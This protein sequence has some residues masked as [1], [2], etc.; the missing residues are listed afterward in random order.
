MFKKTRELLQEREAQ[1]AGAAP[2]TFAE[3]PSKNSQDLIYSASDLKNRVLLVEQGTIQDVIPFLRLYRV[4]LLKGHIISCTYS[5]DS[6]FQPLGVTDSTVLSPGT[7]V[8]IARLPNEP[9]GVIISVI[10]DFVKTYGDSYA[11]EIVQAS[12]AGFVSDLV[13]KSIMYYQPPGGGGIYS[14]KD[15]HLDAIP[16]DWAR[17]S[18]LGA[19]LFLSDFLSGFRLNEYCGIWLH[20]MDSLLR[21]AGLNYQL[22]TGGSEEYS[23][24]YWKAFLHYRGY[25]YSIDSQLGKRIEGSTASPFI[26]TNA[27]YYEHPDSRT[28]NVEHASLAGGDTSSIARLPQHRVQE[29]EGALGQGGARWVVSNKRTS[30]GSGVFP[31]PEM[32]ECRTAQGTYILQSR[33]GILLVKY[34]FVSAPLRISDPDEAYGKPDITEFNTDFQTYLSKSL[35]SSFTG[36]LPL[37]STTHIFDIRNLLCNWEATAGFYLLPKKFKFLKESELYNYFRQKLKLAFGSNVFS[38]A[39]FYMDPFG[40]ILMQNGQGARIELRGGSIRISAPENIYIDAG[41]NTLVFGKKTQILSESGVDIAAKESIRLQVKK[42]TVEEP[43]EDEVE[44]TPVLQTLYDYKNKDQV[45]LMTNTG[46]HYMSGCY[47]VEYLDVDVERVGSCVSVTEGGSYSVLTLPITYQPSPWL[48][49]LYASQAMNQYASSEMLQATTLRA[50]DMPYS[51]N[52]DGSAK[53]PGDVGD[54]ELD[55]IINSFPGVTQVDVG[56]SNMVLVKKS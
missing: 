41:S 50:C 29:W 36:K 5:L 39:I 7:T 23:L 30:S 10:P 21:I 34:P 16:G 18:R 49:N 19:A 31:I 46:R 47:K 22:W 2:P 32:Q 17:F 42:G 15:A 6:S 27:S 24:L 35:A 1:K 44:E 11:D 12:N 54:E 43:T 13:Q 3:R 9:Y 51:L 45:F 33:S 28:S 40:D 37:I 52:E 53:L 4:A 8:L 38:P 55:T 56:I 14:W 26:T 48:Y 20:Y 25:G